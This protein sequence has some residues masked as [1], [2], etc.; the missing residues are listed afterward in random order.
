MRKWL[1][2]ISVA[3]GAFMLLVDV[4]IVNV[5][6][7]SMT[8][9]L[10]ATFAGLQWVIDIYA[11]TL[12]ALLLGLGSLSDRVG[13]KPVYLA[14]LVVFALAS[15]AAGLSVDPTMLIVARG[16]QGVGGAAMFATTIA[17][18]GSSYRGRD[19]ALAFGVW[20]AV[21]G[22]AA[23]AGPILGGLLTQALSWRWVF[24]VNLP[25]SVV[26]VAVSAWVLPRERTA[27]RGGIDVPGVLAFTAVAGAVTAALTRVSDNGWT[28]ATTL[29]LLGAGALGAVAFVAIEARS[30]RPVLD[31]AL[32]RR[33]PL[34]GVLAVALLY[35]V[36]AFAY[37]AYE[38]LWL[39]SVRGLSP[40]Q[41]GLAQMPLALAAFVVS[42]AAGHW[43]HAVSSRWRIGG[44]L[45]LIGAGAL[46][47][48]HLGTGSNWGALLPG[49]VVTGIGVGLATGPLAAAALAAVPAERGGIALGR[50]QHRASARL[51]AW[52]RGARP[53]VPGSRRR[54]PGGDR[55]HPPRRRCRAGDHRRPGARGRRCRPRAAPC[56][57]RSRDPRSLRPRAR[58]D[59][60]R[61]RRRR[62]GR[63]AGHR[64]CAATPAGRSSSKRRS[65]TPPKLTTWSVPTTIRRVDVRRARAPS[66]ASSASCCRS[67]GANAA[68]ARY[69]LGLAE[70]LSRR[71]G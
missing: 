28:S 5:A 11:L 15:L 68:D 39:Q 45:A 46:A 8:T 59:A 27:H 34:P 56:R 24:F 32:L 23:A 50:A 12:A 6:L 69:A 37:L 31:L 67:P 7:P 61:G 49:L 58:R 33:G 4:S 70:S 22:A 53:G 1:P 71:R 62:A 9:D 65:P 55:G 25:V 51:C 10:H 19:R 60:A 64:A 57:A 13:R 35:S 43:L 38:S 63:G 29:G 16:V 41:T 47:Q 26:A 52:D 54:A 3:L 30:R 42:L 36:A 21:N 48:A 40:V 66:P 17:L 20:G 18:L 44:G 2:L 14:G